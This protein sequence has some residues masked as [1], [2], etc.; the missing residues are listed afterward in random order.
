LFTLRSAEKDAVVLEASLFIEIAHPWSDFEQ[1]DPITQRKVMDFCCG[2][3]TEFY[4][5]P[6]FNCLPICWHMNHSCEPNLGLDDENNF[7]A[8]RDINAG[9]ELCWDYAFAETNPAFSMR[10]RCGCQTCRS[11]ITGHDWKTL[12]RDSA[13]Y[14]YMSREVHALTK[15]AR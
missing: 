1:M 13:K 4:A 10:C 6:D 15:A 14:G 2:S 3:E 9:E 8:M 12:A 5:P 7:V 11:V